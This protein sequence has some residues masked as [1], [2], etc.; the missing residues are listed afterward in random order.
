MGVYENKEF[1]FVA[2]VK[3]G[4]VPRLRDEFSPAL[5]NTQCPFR[6]LPERRASRWGDSLT[7]EKMHECRWVK[8]KLVCQVAFVEWTMPGTCVIAPSSP[9]AT[10][11]RLRRLLGKLE[12]I[13]RETET[14]HF[15]VEADQDE[16]ADFSLRTSQLSV[17]HETV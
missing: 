16:S 13:E 5:Q 7:A 17:S 14:R 8:P 15:S 2:K 10:T 1:V 3:N 11:R 6:N 4:F 12:L 9:C